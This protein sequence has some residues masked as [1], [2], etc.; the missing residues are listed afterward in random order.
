MPARMFKND[1]AALRT[2]KADFD[3]IGHAL[4]AKGRL[5]HS[6]TPDSV[7]QSIKWNGEPLDY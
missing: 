1:L 5:D 4:L 7:R 2:L 3:R 6:A